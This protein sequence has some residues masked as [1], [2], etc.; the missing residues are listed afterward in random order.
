MDCDL[1]AFDKYTKYNALILAILLEKVDFAL[2]ILKTK[3]L[4]D[5]DFCLEDKSGYTAIQI[6]ENKV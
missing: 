3:N 2:Q 4:K 1:S 6:A 5:S